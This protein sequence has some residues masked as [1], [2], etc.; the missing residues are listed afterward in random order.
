MTYQQYYCRLCDGYTTGHFSMNCPKGKT[1]YHGTRLSSIQGITYKSLQPSING[2]LG[3]GIYFTDNFE[4]AKQISLR[5]DNEL[6][7][8]VFE[9]N[10][11]RELVKELGDK[12][13][14]AWQNEGYNSASALH[15]PWYGLNTGYFKEYCLKDPRKC[16]LKRVTVTQGYVDGI[17]SLPDS[18][19]DKTQIAWKEL[20]ELQEEPTIN[21]VVAIVDN[22][23]NMSA[24]PN[25]QM[26]NTAIAI[27]PTITQ[28][29]VIP[30]LPYYSYGQC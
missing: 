9:C 27:N 12:N 19:I 14:V 5:F 8:A 24:Q 30:A 20:M 4:I 26:A 1:L 29:S 2:R 3:P 13:L 7:G 11:N 28:T 21:N 10:V 17:Q 25:F 6:G 16:S 22:P 18:V 23:G 15:P